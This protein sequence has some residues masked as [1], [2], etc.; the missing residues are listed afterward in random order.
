MALVPSRS[1]G[2]SRRLARGLVLPALA[3]LALTGT[4]GALAAAPAGAATTPT[5]SIA[6]AG[7]NSGDIQLTYEL[8][9]LP[10]A[11]GSQQWGPNCQA[12]QTAQANTCN[13]YKPGVYVVYAD[14]DIHSATT[15]NDTEAVGF[16]LAAVTAGAT[17]QIA[18]P[19]M[20]PMSNAG[21]QD[22]NY[23][24]VNTS[25]TPAPV[26]GATLTATTSVFE[27]K[28][29]TPAMEYWWADGARV[30]GNGRTYTPT[31]AELGQRLT[32]VT[33]LVGSRNYQVQFANVGPVAAAPAPAA[34]PAGIGLKQTTSAGRRLAVTGV[35]AGWTASVK[36]LRGSK[37]I[38]GAKGTVYK[39]KKADVGKKLHA[40]VTLT[41]G[42]QSKTFTTKKVKVGKLVAQIKTVKASGHKVK[43]TVKVASYTKPAGT[44]KVKFGS[45]G[46]KTVKLKASA[47]GKATIKAPRSFTKG[48]VKVTFTSSLPA[49]Y[50]AKSHSATKTVKL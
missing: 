13:G 44:L 17:T 9:S 33:F 42:T 7:T 15:G 30:L 22:T 40:V 12:P 10:A 49:K 48:K 6:V 25:V 16:A 1:H 5:G 28:N 46:T 37:S 19:P 38:K 21:G 32:V 29:F 2:G 39:A 4:G 11:D 45:K 34:L 26:V 36:W 35:P 43:V 24:D 50:V 23:G 41:A 14:E 27:A 20:H 47:K 3:A 8:R 31:A 18:L